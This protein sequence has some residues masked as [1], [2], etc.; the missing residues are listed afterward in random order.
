MM[1]NPS[2][3]WPIRFQTVREGLDQIDGLIFL[4]HKSYLKMIESAHQA[5]CYLDI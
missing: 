2:N 3:S 5:K 1:A 4:N